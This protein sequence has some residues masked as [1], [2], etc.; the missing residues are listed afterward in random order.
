[1]RSA[2]NNVYMN[3]KTLGPTVDL[4]GLQIGPPGSNVHWSVTWI[5]PPLVEVGGSFLE[6]GH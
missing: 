4:S 5:V 3:D 6:N 1:M 2:Q